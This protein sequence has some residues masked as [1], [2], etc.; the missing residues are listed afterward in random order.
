MNGLLE[1]FWAKPAEDPEAIPQFPLPS[2]SPN[3]IFH[4]I[5][6]RCRPPAWSPLGDD[7]AVRGETVGPL[8]RRQLLTS[9]TN[10]L[11][12]PPLGARLLAE[13]MGRIG[14]HIP[15]RRMVAPMRD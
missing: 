7:A 8:Y 1:F 2:P 12:A 10:P 6:A 4:K 5:R 14:S 9:K 15:R 13:E 11:Q 3:G